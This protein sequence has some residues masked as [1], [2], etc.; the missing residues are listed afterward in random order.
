MPSKFYE[1]VKDLEEGEKVIWGDRKQ[2]LTVT[3]V[4]GDGTAVVEGPRGGLYTIFEC[5]GASGYDYSISN[6]NGTNWVN[7]REIERK[8]GVNMYFGDKAGCY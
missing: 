4:N 5:P 6:E 7:V 2:W 1:S 8:D 3:E